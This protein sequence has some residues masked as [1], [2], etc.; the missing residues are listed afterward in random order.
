MI[1]DFEVTSSTIR[2]HFLPF[3]YAEL[4]QLRLED[5]AKELE[6]NI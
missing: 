3:S 2:M 1:D 5:K 6:I 4:K